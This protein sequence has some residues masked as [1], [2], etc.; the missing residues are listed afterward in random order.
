MITAE[1]VT[2]QGIR[3]IGFREDTMT[4]GKGKNESL[5]NI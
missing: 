5:T 2:A 1:N 3:D 4:I